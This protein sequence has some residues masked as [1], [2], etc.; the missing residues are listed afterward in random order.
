MAEAK[1]LSTFTFVLEYEGTNS[2]RQI[3][4]SGPE[5]AL[6]KWQN[7][8]VNPVDYGLRPSSAN[9]LAECLEKNWR[10]HLERN[11]AIGR[12]E[13]F[14]R[15]LDGLTNVWCVWISVGEQSALI[16][17]IATRARR[18][19][20]AITKAGVPLDVRDEGRRKNR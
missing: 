14:V 2:V 10:E 13:P 18:I 20:P 16:N 4:A 12:R 3:I 1:S 11:A 6:R 19:G 5:A 15:S 8:L 17:I 7:G 9:S